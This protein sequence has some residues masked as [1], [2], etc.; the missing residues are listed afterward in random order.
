LGMQGISKWWWCCFERDWRRG[1]HR[2]KTKG[3]R[4]DETRGRDFLMLF[5][6]RR[7]IDSV[8]VFVIASFLCKT[9]NV[10]NMWESF[11]QKERRRKWE[12]RKKGRY[13]VGHGI[14]LI[15]IHVFLSLISSSSLYLRF[16]HFGQSLVV[17]SFNPPENPWLFIPINSVFSTRFS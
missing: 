15:S 11:R 10:A 14:H 4:I 6:E 8:Y 9:C 12:T 2:K 16:L 3:E 13:H 1:I 17:A 5:K 7:K